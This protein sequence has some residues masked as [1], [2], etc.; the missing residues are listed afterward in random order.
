MMFGG[1]HPEFHAGRLR[2]LGPLIGEGAAVTTRGR[3]GLGIHT[4]LA[5]ARVV[6]IHVVVDEHAETLIDVVAEQL[7][8]GHG[9]GR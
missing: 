5:P 6:G 9:L 3:K 1:E 4:I 8:H 7:L 2:R